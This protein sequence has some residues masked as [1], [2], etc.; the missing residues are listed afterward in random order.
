M[1]DSLPDMRR[2]Q[3]GE[4][5]PE[6]TLTDVVTRNPILSYQLWEK[7][8]AVLVFMRYL[9]CVFCR[10]HTA[11]LQEDISAFRE[12][13]VTIALINFE[14]EDATQRYCESRNLVE[15]FLCLTDKEKLAYRAFNLSRT[16]AGR[17]FTPQV[18]KRGFQAALHGHL[19]SVPKGDPFQMPGVFIV[20]TEGIIRYAYRSKD[21]SDNPPTE[22]ILALLRELIP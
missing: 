20:D 16:N 1:T 7:K 13:G 12:L 22:Q 5:A 11:R 6:V 2:P 8:P 10:E 19:N 18:W 17:I 21:A 3:V 14:S 15:P 4:A 9:G